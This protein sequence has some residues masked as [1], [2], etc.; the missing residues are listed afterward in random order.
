MGPTC[1]L[2][3]ESELNKLIVLGAVKKLS[4][5]TTVLVAVSI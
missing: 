2:G 3:P 5:R 4:A 1:A